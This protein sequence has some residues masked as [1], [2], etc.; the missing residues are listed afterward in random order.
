MQPRGDLETETGFG[1]QP[2]ARIMWLGS[3]YS[4]DS[5]RV[6]VNHTIIGGI[7]SCLHVTFRARYNTV[8]M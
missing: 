3:I 7:S 1:L 4:D 5:L 2:Q 6:R 8:M